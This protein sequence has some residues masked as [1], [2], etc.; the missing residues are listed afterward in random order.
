MI[1][2]KKEI[3]EI[4]KVLNF[5]RMFFV[6]FSVI[7]V[8]SSCIHNVK[9][10]PEIL[11]VKSIPP[12]KAI[13][14]EVVIINDQQ[15][16][17]ED[18]LFFS[19]GAHSWTGNLHQY[20]DKAIAVLKDALQKRNIKVKP[21]AEKKLKLSILKAETDCHFILKYESN[22]I[23]KVETGN[24]IA[25]EIKAHQNTT[26][27]WEITWANEQAI[28]YAVIDILKND[29]IIGYLKE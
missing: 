14:T 8:F 24:G 10:D 28:R 21:D 20:T 15:K 1:F 9:P 27:Q 7:V 23:M 2:Q 22:L 29:K 4:K 26:S 11:E 12:L 19:A 3:C 16:V 25:V 5:S 13:N 17:K 6:L 18:H